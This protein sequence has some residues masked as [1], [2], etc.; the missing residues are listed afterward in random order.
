[1][2]H[3]LEATRLVEQKRNILDEPIPNDPTLVLQLTPW[4]PSN[5]E[6]NNKQNIKMSL[7]KTCKKTTNVFTIGLQ[8]IIDFCEWLLNYMP[9]KPKVVDTVLAYFKTKW[10]S[11]WKRDTLFKPSQSK[12]ALKNSAIQYQRK[13]L[14]AFDPESFPLNSKQLITNLMIN[15]RQ[16]KV[17]SFV[18]DGEGWFKKWW[19]D[20]QRG[21]ISFLKRSP[22]RMYDSSE[23]FS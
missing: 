16:T 7:Q 22:L 9:P 20:S 6:L 1:M 23:L 19:S 2:L 4:R 10:K 11:S 5:I 13:G 3:A 14:N 17:D 8:K 15:K 21:S 12:S 18:Y